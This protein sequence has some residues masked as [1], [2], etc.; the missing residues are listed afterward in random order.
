ME[1]LAAVADI[2]RFDHFLMAAVLLLFLAMF[3]FVRAVTRAYDRQSFLYVNTATANLVVQLYYNTLPDPTRAF[4]VITPKNPTQMSLTSFSLFGIL[5]FVN[6][7]WK[8]QHGHTKA[9][10]R[11]PSII[12]VSPW[13]LKSVRQ[14]LNTMVR[15]VTP[16]MVHTH[17]TEGRRITQPVAVPEISDEPPSYRS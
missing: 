5:M 3:A 6:K 2:R 17:A 9:R 14:A 8:L 15:T 16:P 7:P 10:N 1:W 12:Y 13:K 4:S 11:L